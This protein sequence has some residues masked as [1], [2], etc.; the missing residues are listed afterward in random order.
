MVRIVIVGASGRMGQA[1]LREAA[2]AAELR[3][4]GA[5]DS[6]VSPA[7]GQDAGVHAGLAPLGVLI[8]ADLAV[9]AG[10]ADVVVDFSAPAALAA[11]I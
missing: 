1:L 2:R 9:V 7:L 5:V 6:A 3:V 4:V 10:A 8:G 11:T